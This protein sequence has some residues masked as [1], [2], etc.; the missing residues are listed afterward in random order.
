[1]NA[2]TETVAAEG[3]SKLADVVLFWISGIFRHLQSPRLAMYLCR[4]GQLYSVDRHYNTNEPRTALYLGNVTH[5]EC[6]EAYQ[7]PNAYQCGDIEDCVVV[8]A[9]DLSHHELS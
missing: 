4:G 7:C 9:S 1:M 2:T 5:I 6:G 3:L 8:D